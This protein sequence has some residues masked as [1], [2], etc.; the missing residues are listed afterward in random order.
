MSS[1]NVACEHEH[2]VNEGEQEM[3]TGRTLGQ[4]IPFSVSRGECQEPD[5]KSS[6]MSPLD[7]SIKK[8]SLIAV[9]CVVIYSPSALHCS[10]TPHVSYGNTHSNPLPTQCSR[11]LSSSK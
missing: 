11:N 8:A 2:C 7:S 10:H 3:N 1:V 6:V 4:Y 9:I 5:P